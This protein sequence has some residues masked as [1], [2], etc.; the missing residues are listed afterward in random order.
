MRPSFTPISARSTPDTVARTTR[1]FLIT[2]SNVSVMSSRI[3]PPTP[4]PVKTR[5]SLTGSARIPHPRRGRA[6]D[7]TAVAL[8]QAVRDK[9]VSP[10]ELVREC[11]ANIDRRNPALRAF[12]TVDAEGALAAARGL[13]AEAAA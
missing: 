3:A 6:M 2:R 12:I 13:E 5:A 10:V 1:T 8:A 11:L 4:L 7:F 9:R